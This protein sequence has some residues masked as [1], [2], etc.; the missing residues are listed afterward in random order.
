MRSSRARFLRG[1]GA[2]LAASAFAPAAR[3]ADLLPLTIA[4]IPSDIS[5]EAFYAHELGF[6]K[7]AGIDAKLTPLN[8][9]A[10]IAAAVA[11]GSANVG[12]SNVVSLAAAHERGLPFTILAPANLHVQ[13]APTAGILAVKKS[14]PIQSAKDLTGKTVAVIG[15]NNIAHVATRLWIDKNGGDSGAVKFLELPFSEMSPAVVAG[16]VDAA[17]LDAI[18]DPT[19]GKPDD[20]IRRLGSTFDAVGARFAPSVWFSTTEWVASHPRES[21]SFVA[22]MRETA[23][24]ANGHHKESAQ[25]LTRYA[26]QT[27]EG[28]QAV[29]RATFGD[30]MTPELIQP[31]IDAAAKYGAIKAAF[32][33][34]DI[35]SPVANS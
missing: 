14:S 7:K 24:W 23:K 32:P 18:G 27:L 21:R 33:A 35:I 11:G 6:F 8:N 25:I 3:A 15:L 1:T 20:P 19:A 17:A 2:A 9:G 12:Y 16:R 22:V 26:H 13:G 5:G 30:R 31:D 28:I 4:A 10:S 29:T 34:A